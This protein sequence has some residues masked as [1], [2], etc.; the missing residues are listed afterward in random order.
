MIS[1]TIN[2]SMKCERHFFLP[3]QKEVRFSF[4]ITWAVKMTAVVGEIFWDKETFFERKCKGT[5]L[6]FCFFLDFKVG[7]QREKY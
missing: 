3:S 1:K 2:L 5:D 7:G 4:H 6:N